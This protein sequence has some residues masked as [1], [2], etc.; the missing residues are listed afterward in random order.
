MSASRAVVVGG[1]L[2]GLSIARALTERGLTDVLVLERGLL[3]SGGTGKSS[4]IVRAHY[5]VPS[6]AAMAWRSLPVFEALGAEVGFRQVGYTVVV[7]EENAGPLKDNTAMHQGLGIEVDLVDP[8]QVAAL[9]PMMNVDDVAL[10]GYEPR[11]GFAD[12]TQL[13]LHYGQRARAHGARVRQN[14]PVARV[15]TSGS[16]VTGVELADG[17]VVEADL[18]VVA[19]GWWSARLLA[20]LGVDFPVEAYRSELL[21][22]DT[23]APLPDLPVVSDLVSLQYCRLEGSGQFLVGNSD[24]AD[25]GRKLVDPDHYSNHASDASLEAYAE[26]LLH[27]FPGFPDPSVTHTYAGVYDVPPDWNP[28]I[29]PVGDVDGLPRARGRQHRPR[30]ARVGLP[31]V[32]LRRG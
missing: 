16:R 4:G 6:I 17:E 2:I 22:V 20:D 1:G 25:F 18:V 21:V 24:H 13:A 30:R 5:G 9:W 26:K 31:P 29:G 27:R 32:A 3:A 11:G 23:G 12:A 8:D 14:A 7:G 15:V 19:A 10:G 28:V